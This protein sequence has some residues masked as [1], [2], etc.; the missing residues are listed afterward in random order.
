LSQ[1]LQLAL[2]MRVPTLTPCHNDLRLS[3]IAVVKWCLFW[4]GCYSS[5]NSSRPGC[6]NRKGV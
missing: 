3:V 2:H 6:A 4:P 5:A 1:L